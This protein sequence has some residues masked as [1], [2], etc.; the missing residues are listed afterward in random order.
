MSIF[1]IGDL[2]LDGSGKKPMD[3][4]GE[5]WI[6]HEGKIFKSWVESVDNDDLILVPGDI[7]WALKLEEAYFDLKRI[8]ELPGIKILIKGN[9]DY[10]WESKKK[11]KE[12]GLESI[13][14]LQ[15]DCFVKDNVAIAGAR[16]WISKD[17]EEFNEHDEKIYNRE[18]NRLE[19][20][21]KAVD[22]DVDSIL[23]ML[24]YPPFNIKDNSPNEFVSLMKQYNV[25]MCLYGHL[26]SQGHKFAVEGNVE[27]INFLCVSSDYLDFKLK[28]I[29]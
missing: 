8:D 7:S 15:N 6:N 11:L 12:L 3:I 27:G 16:G 2:H 10:W 25:S 5:E 19:L 22:K 9:H 1:A 14:F 4:F 24:H 20:S 17:Y 13:F 29:L 18:L 21:L 23:V 28:K 26:H